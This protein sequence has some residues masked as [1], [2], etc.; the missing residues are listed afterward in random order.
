MRLSSS[1]MIPTSTA[2]PATALTD[3]GYVVDR[4]FDGEEDTIQ[5]DRAL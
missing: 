3:A 4:A 2:S 1:S 5:G